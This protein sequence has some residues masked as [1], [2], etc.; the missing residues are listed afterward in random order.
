MKTRASL[1]Y[2]VNDCSKHGL[3]YSNSVEQ[4]RL[5]K[6]NFYPTFTQYFSIGSICYK[7]NGTRYLGK[8]PLF[9]PYK[10]V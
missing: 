9:S 7:Q 4:K 3:L 2:F 1:K 5:L 8:K 6:T 10:T